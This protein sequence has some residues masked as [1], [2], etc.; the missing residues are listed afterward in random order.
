MPQLEQALRSHG[1][2]RARFPSGS[3]LLRSQRRECRSELLKRASTQ[4]A[5][6][7]RRLLARNK[8]YSLRNMLRMGQNL[9]IDER[10]HFAKRRTKWALWQE[11]SPGTPNKSDLTARS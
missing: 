8:G 3:P 6:T 5:C 7:D 1:K 9:G 2:L 11:R 4:P 10:V